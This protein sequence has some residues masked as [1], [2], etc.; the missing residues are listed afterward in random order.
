MF[1]ILNIFS[2]FSFT[3]VHPDTLSGLRC[4]LVSLLLSRLLPE[5]SRETVPSL[6][7][8]HSSLN[9]TIDPILFIMLRLIFT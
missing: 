5:S 7:S 1:S 6:T 3:D 4:D 2:P 8:T 9:H